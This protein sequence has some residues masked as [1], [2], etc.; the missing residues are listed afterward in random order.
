MLWK[1]VRWN[2]ESWTGRHWILLGRQKFSL[3]DDP[4]RRERFWPL[5]SGH[6]QMQFHCGVIRFIHNHKL[7]VPNRVSQGNQFINWH[8]IIALSAEIVF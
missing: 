8:T 4:G 5:E 1:A 2:I 6:Y 3:G 7:C